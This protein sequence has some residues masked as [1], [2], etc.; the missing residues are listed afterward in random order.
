MQHLARPQP[1]TLLLLFWVQHGTKPEKT[2]AQ[3]RLLLLQEPRSC[4]PG[5]TGS[6]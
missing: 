4:P 5:A 3:V 2:K 1:Q 6:C